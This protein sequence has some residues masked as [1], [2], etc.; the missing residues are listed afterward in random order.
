VC[1]CVCVCVYIYICLS[2]FVVHFLDPF[3]HTEVHSMQCVFV[4][5]DAYL[6]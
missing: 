2:G 1:V 6:V 3:I 4:G 5:A